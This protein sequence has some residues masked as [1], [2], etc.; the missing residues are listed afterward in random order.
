MCIIVRRSS[1]N[2]DDAKTE[3][4]LTEAR[5]TNPSYD[6]GDIFETE[7]TPRTFGRIAA[8]T[9]KQVVVQ[10]IREAGTVQHL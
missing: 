10:R 2:W 6:V 5:K 8:Q 1:K 4:E 3:I 7:V 9:A